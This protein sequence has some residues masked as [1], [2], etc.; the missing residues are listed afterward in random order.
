MKSA[1]T[2][3]MELADFFILLMWILKAQLALTS[4][5]KKKEVKF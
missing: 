1:L 4:K 3:I 2:L 5:L